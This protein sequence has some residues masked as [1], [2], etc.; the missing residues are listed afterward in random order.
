MIQAGEAPA[1]S[2]LVRIVHAL[3]DAQQP[4]AA[5]DLTMGA[6]RAGTEADA[7][8]FGE[9]LWLFAK[10]KHVAQTEAVLAWMREQDIEVE[11]RHLKA[12]AH[13]KGEELPDPEPEPTPEPTAEPADPVDE[14]AAAAES[15]PTDPDEPADWERQIE[16]AVTAPSQS[17]EEAAAPA[18]PEDQAAPTDD[19]AAAAEEGT[20]GVDPEPAG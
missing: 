2:D 9:L 17:A 10:P 1:A 11:H 5:L 4:E 18:A 14:E 3:L 12:V 16:G 19:G 15:A 13:A 8:N 7:T 20:S 6:L